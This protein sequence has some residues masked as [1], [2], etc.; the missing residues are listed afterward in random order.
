[1]TRWKLWVMRVASWGAVF[2]G[3]VVEAAV[4]GM[5]EFGEVVVVATVGHVAFDELPQAFD[6]IQVRGLRLAA[7]VACLD[8]LR[9][10]VLVL[11]GTQ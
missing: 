9:Q 3:D 8:N 11:S 6:Q 5:A 2:G 7:R 1:M 4:D 10:V